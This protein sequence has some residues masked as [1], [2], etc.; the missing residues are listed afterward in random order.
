MKKVLVDAFAAERIEVI[1]GGIPAEISP[2]I[3]EEKA[4]LPLLFAVDFALGDITG[5]ARFAAQTA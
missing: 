3:R 4:L 2:V 5:Q 1:F